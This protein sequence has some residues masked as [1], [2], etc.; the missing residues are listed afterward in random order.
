MVEVQPQST[1]DR[2]W[3]NVSLRRLYGVPGEPAVVLYNPGPIISGPDG[4]SYCRDY[5]DLKIKQFDEDG[6]FTQAYVGIGEGPGE[7]SS[8]SEAAVLGDSVIYV[9]DLDNRKEA[10]FDIES[11]TNLH[12]KSD[13]PAFGYRITHGRHLRW[14]G[15]GKY[16]ILEHWSG[17]AF[18][19]GSP[20]SDQQTSSL[21]RAML[22]LL[23]L[24]ATLF[25]W[26]LAS[27]S[28]H[29]VPAASP[30]SLADALAARVL[31][32]FGGGEAW[33]R[34][35]YIQFSYSVQQ[36]HDRIRVIR[37]LW[38][39]HTG[40]YRMEIPGPANTPYVVLF[41]RNTRRG[42]AYWNGVE[43]DDKETARK[44]AEAM[45]RATTDGYPLLAPFLLFDPGVRRSYQADSTDRTGDVL[46][47]SHQETDFLAGDQYWLRVDKATGRVTQWS[48][49]RSGDNPDRPLRSFVWEGYEEHVTAAGRLVFSTRKRAVASP[50]VIITADIAVPVSVPDDMFTDSAPRL[51][52]DPVPDNK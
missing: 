1:A 37:H 9:A 13:L 27:V 42:K 23:S 21:H 30:D 47:V 8:L 11:A 10:F 22:Q 18:F 2:N 24:T 25:C 44:L 46:H 29:P 26:T 38:S 16:G 14:A 49:R 3:Q 12:S 35:P 4:F 51:A 31:D 39:R 33:E 5:G 15:T 41:N 28:P 36:G 6:N 32:A 45:R 34:L 19:N 40:E 48:Y 50:F 7:F 52:S 17:Q 43:L 20:C